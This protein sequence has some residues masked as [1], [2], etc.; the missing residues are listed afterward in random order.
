MAAVVGVAA[1]AASGAAAAVQYDTVFEGAPTSALAGDLEAA[2]QLVTLAKSPPDTLT[3]LR[4]RAEGDVARLKRLVDAAGYW[5]SALTFDIAS[6]APDH[7]TVTV[8]VQPG[9]LYTLAG[10]EVVGAAGQ[11]P[12]P[13]LPKPDDLGL[14]IGGPAQSAPVL[15]AEPKLARAYQTRG[16]PYA[17]VADRRVVVDHGTRTMAVTFT[18]DPGPQATVGATTIT[19]LQRLE[20]AYVD[21]RIE[22]REGQPY[23]VG[24]LDRARDA[25]IASGLFSV[26]KV[27][28]A[29]AL[30]PDGRVPIQVEL[31]ERPPRSIGASA[32]YDTS[33]GFSVTAFWEHRNLFGGAES[34]HTELTVGES[35]KSATATFRRPDLFQRDLDLLATAGFTDETVDAYTSVREKLFGGVERKLG[36]TWTL[37]LGGQ[38]ERANVTQA[39][40]PRQRYAL[41]GIP[42]YARY[43]GTDDLLNPTTG[44]RAS[45]ELTPY[46]GLP[47][48]D[49]DF[50]AGKLRGSAYQAVDADNR[51]IVAGYAALGATSGVSLTALPR[52]KRLYAGGGGSVRGYAFQH[53]GPLDVHNNPIGGRSSLELGTELRIRITETIGLVPFLEAGTVYRS[54]FPDFSGH[55][56]VGT[57]LGARYYTAIGPVRLDV[58]V[59]LERRRK[60]SPFQVYISIGQAF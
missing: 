1:M 18:L 27:T 13:P 22:W 3:A 17:K 41:A 35:N 28:P 10:V 21:R 25:L 20:R 6:S 36:K 43:D 2:S 4:V 12:P 9:P 53:A 23:D 58:G 42:G 32:A 54:P 51:W 56:F 8:R 55:L 49:L 24:Q 46:L 16:Y 60:D 38:A 45:V 34:L 33:L 26:V 7:A 5:D 52:D 29:P 44:G 57:G 30:G 19:G 59:P 47:G 15:A 48:T 11:M 31:T 39:F 50:V 14:T 40:E 37:G